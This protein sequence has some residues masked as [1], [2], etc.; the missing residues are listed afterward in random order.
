MTTTAISGVPQRLS[1]KSDLGVSASEDGAAITL[2]PG[3]RPTTIVVPVLVDQRFSE[4][5]Q[6]ATLGVHGAW[7][8]RKQQ[9]EEGAVLER[10]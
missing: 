6:A 10:A 2:H 1:S 5:H 4:E 9:L 8:L 3:A 7:R